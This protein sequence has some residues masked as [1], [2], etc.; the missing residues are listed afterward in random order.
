MYNNIFSNNLNDDLDRAALE[1]NEKKNKINNTAMNDFTN[2]SKELVKGI[3]Y[4]SEPANT[5]FLPHSFNYADFNNNSNYDS[6]SNININSNNSENISKLN[7]D[8]VFDDDNFDDISDI[9]SIIS[10][11]SAL[12]SNVKNTLRLNTSHINNISDNKDD[13][14]IFNHVKN[15]NECRIQL[16]KILKTENHII[17]KNKNNNNNTIT[18]IIIII[19]LGVFIIIL[20]DVFMNN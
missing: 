11:K 8:S 1:I 14:A 12:S 5:K 18:N 10:N 17:K 20:L 7:S 15:C 19:L 3:N 6:N 9:N 13:I 2:Q 16:I 4:L